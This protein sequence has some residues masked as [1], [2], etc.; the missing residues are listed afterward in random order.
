[1]RTMLTIL[2]LGSL[3]AAGCGSDH[4]QPPASSAPA[5]T[6][7]ACAKLIQYCPTGYVWSNYLTD[8]QTCRAIFDCTYDLSPTAC[9]QSLAQ[10]FDCLAALTDASG[11]KACEGLVSQ[12]QS[13]CPYPQ[14]CLG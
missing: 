3:L 2:T 12:V 8:E 9:R 14:D 7:L 13:T 10:G 1:M 6:G 4:H 5:N 11:C